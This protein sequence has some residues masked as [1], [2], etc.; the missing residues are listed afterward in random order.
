MTY[1]AAKMPHDRYRSSSRRTFD[2]R[3]V[4]SGSA[5][6]CARKFARC[7]AI[8]RYSTVSSGLRRWYLGAWTSSGACTPTGGVDQ[9]TV[10]RFAAKLDRLDFAAIAEDRLD[11]RRFAIVVVS[12]DQRGAADPE[13]NSE[14]SPRTVRG[15]VTPLG[16]GFSGCPG[17][18]DICLLW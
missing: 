11:R 8:T 2:G 9:A 13:S 17:K 12:V 1:P 3:P 10:T 6:I 5:S 18:E 16:R 7:S 14:R 15:A 4:R